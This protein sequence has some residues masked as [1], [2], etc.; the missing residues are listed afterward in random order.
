MNH[1]HKEWSS[2]LAVKTQEILR[3]A[4]KRKSY[5]VKL[6]DSSLYWLLLFIAIVG[7]FIVSVVLVPIL[8]IESGWPL[9]VSLFFIGAS[10]GW[11]FSF[12]IHSLEKI[13]KQH[14][15]I[16]SIFIPALALINVGIFA[17]LS[18]RLIV[19]MHLPT[20]PHNAFLVGA[21]YVLGYVLPDSFS[22]FRRK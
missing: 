8:L 11:D 22:H 4:E 14:H 12:I 15:I 13:E 2:D 7:N 5:W 17:V 1:V 10:F 19:L 21:V 20:A 9:Y 18:N 6:I 16:A 3:R